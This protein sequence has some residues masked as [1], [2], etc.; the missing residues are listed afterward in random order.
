[1]NFP[2]PTA[3]SLKRVEKCN[4]RCKK[5]KCAR[6]IEKILVASVNNLLKLSPAQGRGEHS[7][8]ISTVATVGGFCK[9][10]IKNKRVG[11]NEPCRG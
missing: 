11:G 8:M 2:R 3:R 1:M 9:K 6:I 4:K 5:E 10:K 7:L